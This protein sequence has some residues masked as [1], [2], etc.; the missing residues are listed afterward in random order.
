M[1]FIIGLFQNF[2][3]N[4]Q[5]NSGASTSFNNML[6][7]IPFLVFVFNYDFSMRGN[8][9][10]SSLHVLERGS[11][12]VFFSNEHRGPIPGR[13]RLKDFPT[14][15]WCLDKISASTSNRQQCRIFIK[16][17][18]PD[19]KAKLLLPIY[20]NKLSSDIKVS[21]LRSLKKINFS[22]SFLVGYFKQEMSMGTLFT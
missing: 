16:G 15:W 12:L 10:H 17:K 2:Y 19:Q 4:C 21:V 13:K 5:F 7:H 22:Y 11:N 9:I 6:Q 14:N 18:I 1:L 3:S 20:I 8:L